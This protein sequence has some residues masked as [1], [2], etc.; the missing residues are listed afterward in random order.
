MQSINSQ[1]VMSPSIAG[2]AFIKL[3]DESKYFKWSFEME[4]FLRTKALWNQ[5]VFPSVHFAELFITERQGPLTI[6]ATAEQVAARIREENIIIEEDTR[7]EWKKNDG[8]AT[9][10]IAQSVGELFYPIIRNPANC[11]ARILW[12]ALATRCNQVNSSLRLAKEDQYN[13]IKM[14]EKETLRGY[15]DRVTGTADEL[16]AMGLLLDEERICSKILSTM[17][18]KY[19]PIRLTIIMQPI[20]NITINNLRQ[21]FTLEGINNNT[22]KKQEDALNSTAGYPKKNSNFKAGVVCHYCNKEGHYKSDCRSKIRDTQQQRNSNRNHSNNN[23]GNSNYYKGRPQTNRQHQPA[24]QP[25]QQQQQQQQCQQ[26]PA[27]TQ[28]PRQTNQRPQLRRN[29]HAKIIEDREKETALLSHGKDRTQWILDSG[30]TRHMTPDK[31][32]LINL[33]ELATPVIVKAA[34]E[35]ETDEEN[36][37]EGDA[38]IRSTHGR[39]VLLQ[40]VLFVPTIRRSL[41]S[42]RKL[43]ENGATV[44]FEHSYCYVYSPGDTSSLILTFALN[45][46]NLYELVYHE[47]TSTTNLPPTPTSDI[48]LST[49]VE[50]WH[51]RL[52]H[53]SISGLKKLQDSGNIPDLNLSGREVIDCRACAKGKLPRDAFKTKNEIHTKAP[54]EI[55]HSDV[56]GPISPNTISGNRY[57]VTYTDDYSRYSFIQF[58]KT[59]DEQEKKFKEFRKL[60]QVQFSHPIKFLRTDSGGEFTSNAFEEYLKRKGIVH[61]SKPPRTPQWRGVSERLNRTLLD[62]VRSML[63]GRNL[64]NYF[65]AEAVRYA[66]DLKNISPTKLLTITPHERLF[67]TKPDYSL[68]RTFGSKIEFKDNAEEKKLDDK[69]TSGIYLGYEAT[70]RCHKVFAINSRRTT[71]AREVIFYEDDPNQFEASPDP[72][73]EVEESKTEEIVII[74]E[75]SEEE[76]EIV[77]AH[78]HPVDQQLPLNQLQ[79]QPH[80]VDHLPAPDHVRVRIEPIGEVP[81]DLPPKRIRKQTKYFQ[82]EVLT[83]IDDGEEPK[84]YREILEREDRDEWI[85]ATLKEIENLYDNDTFEFVEK[86]KDTPLVTS[87]WVFKLKTRPDGSVDKYKARL[88]ARGFTQ[89]QG[90][91]YTETFAPTLRMETIRI[92]LAFALQH[93]LCVHHMDVNGAF[94]NGHLEEEIHMKLPDGFAELH[95]DPSFFAN[96]VAKLKK[97]IYGLKQSMRRWNIRLV[98]YLLSQGYVQSHADPSLF[99][100]R[101]EKNEIKSIIATYVDDCILIG[102]F[103]EITKAKEVL[104]SEFKM[105]DLN[106]MSGILGVNVIQSADSIALDQR[107]YLNRLLQKFG[108]LDCRPVSIPALPEKINQI[109]EDEEAKKP[110]DQNLYRQAVGSLLYLSKCT[111]PDVTYAVNQVAKNMEKPTQEDWMKVKR[112]FRYLKGTIDYALTYARGESNQAIGYSD[113]SYAMNEDRKSTSGYVFLMN[114]TA[115]T[116]RS[117]KQPIVTTSSMEAEFIALA[118]ATKEALWIR[119]LENELLN[120]TNVPTVIMEDNQACIRFSRDYVHSD[121]SKHIDVRYYFIRERIERNEVKM[122]YCPTT[123]MIADALTKPLGPILFAKFASAMGLRKFEILS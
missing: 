49:T 30:C 38:R 83:T 62:K 59:K 8:K 52:G 64:P 26:Q 56:C 10:Y 61:Q 47:D 81:N 102:E 90:I 44:E 23:Y 120:E 43:C 36:R 70:S 109:N 74:D 31:K 106:E 107:A 91:D 117:K 18:P 96:K 9:A 78:P 119:K 27:P 84:S 7:K 122:I 92:L 76:E 100:L 67:G 4:M 112:I 71:Y 115:I 6:N 60:F 63:K 86:P 32:G 88:V 15:L 79:A 123:E 53:L 75:D 57:F 54:G 34:F 116:W 11:T 41:I 39:T 3:T 114:G 113:A 55:I 20:G 118:S 98:T 50:E 35:T 29:D 24:Q 1:Q 68:F 66:N 105:T 22:P 25:Q 69:T 28:S 48:A 95:E 46:E 33:R 5:I 89:T 99:I 51:E 37:V 58:M 101:S 80:P 40:N 14:E 2:T 94:L 82:D 45:K 65:W 85:D 93:H 111:R 103:D 121:R 108:M 97:T 16:A 72:R 13:R 104:S 21:Q 42:V 110:F 17:L 12:T 73:L 87:K 19:E 77:N